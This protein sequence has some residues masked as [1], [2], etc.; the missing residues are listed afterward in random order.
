M[1]QPQTPDRGASFPGHGIDTPGPVSISGREVGTLESVRE[2]PPSGPGRIAPR[3]RRVILAAVARG[4]VYRGADGRDWGTTTSRLNPLGKV[5]LAR[6]K[7]AVLETEGVIRLDG[8][9]W[10]L[11]DS[12]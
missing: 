1:T 12:T 3:D 10:R 4:G 6:W 8:M 9:M 11:A 2:E 7:V 5:P